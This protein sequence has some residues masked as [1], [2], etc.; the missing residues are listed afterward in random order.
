MKNLI[1]TFLFSCLFFL[2]HAQPQTH[3][4]QER[5]KPPHLNQDNEIEVRRIAFLSSQIALTP[6]EAALIKRLPAPV[7]RFFERRFIVIP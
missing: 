3:T 1:V 5:V 7:E 6:A 2:A 4:P